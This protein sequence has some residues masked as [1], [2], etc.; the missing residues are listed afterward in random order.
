M[1]ATAFAVPLWVD[2]LA[3]GIGSLQGAMFASEYKDRRLDLLGIAIIGIATGL[4]GG[5]LRDVLLG[6]VPRAMTSNWY[7]L[8]AVAA[9]IVGMA[10][11]RVFTRLAGVITVLDALTIGLLGAI[12]STKALSLGLPEIPA[13]FVGVIAAV[14]GSVLRDLLMNLTIAMMHVGSLYA[15][16]AA[17]GTI[18]LVVAVSLGAPVAVSAIAGT[19]ITLVIR[20]LAVRFGWT[21][22]EQRA[23]S[24]LPRWRRP[25]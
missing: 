5:V 2:L 8:V 9:A 4:G 17:G 3:V 1:H 18:V 12:G 21:L 10:L 24:R 13:V 14:G 23:L 15:V 7:L 19:S 20:M 16:A 22:P 6:E 25:R 11:Q